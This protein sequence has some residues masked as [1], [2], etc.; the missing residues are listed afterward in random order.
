MVEFIGIY[1]ELERKE[2]IAQETKRLEKSIKDIN[3]LRKQATL[4]RLFAEAAF[5]AV[6]LEETRLIIVRDGIIEEYQ[7][8]ANQRGIKKAAAVEVYD[9]MVNT[10]AKVIEQI[11]KTLPESSIIDPAEDIMKFAMGKK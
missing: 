2:K 11:N 3:D 8:G 7:N 5:M 10:Y 6:T 9:K 4:T 1:T